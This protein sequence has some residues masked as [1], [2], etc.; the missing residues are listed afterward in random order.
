MKKNAR[1]AAE[2]ASAAAGEHA[3]RLSAALARYQQYCATHSGCRPRYH[4]LVDSEQLRAPLLDSPTARNVRRGTD[5]K[6]EA[7]TDVGGVGK[8]R[9]SDPAKKRLKFA[10]FVSRPR[11]A[12]HYSL[13]L[14]V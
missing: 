2:Q 14:G 5:L 7:W 9:R 8:G 1:S 12:S 13:S 11:V 3:E 4:L 6:R 10:D